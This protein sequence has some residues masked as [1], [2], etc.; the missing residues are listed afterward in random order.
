MLIKRHDSSLIKE[1]QVTD[2]AL[3]L[4][5]RRFLR[6]SAGLTTVA[7]LADLLKPMEAYAETATLKYR[8]AKPL[9]PPDELTPID[10]DRTHQFTFRLNYR[11]PVDFRIGFEH[12]E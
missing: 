11:F 8:P 3:Y 4:E 9:G 10:G 7:A 1:S 6:V 2:P 5:R 12:G